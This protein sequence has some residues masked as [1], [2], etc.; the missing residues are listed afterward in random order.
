MW[1]PFKP[2]KHHRI[3]SLEAKVE[4]IMADL[5]RLQSSVDNLAAVAGTVV[6]G[7]EDLKAH[8]ENPE[9]QARIDAAADKIEAAIAT[10]QGALPPAA[11]P[12]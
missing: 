5:S 11:P 4:T 2:A 1:W 10:L 8:A 9:T 12:T 6:A 7:I 3:R